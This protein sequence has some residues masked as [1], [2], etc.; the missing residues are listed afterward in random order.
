[1]KPR[2]LHCFSCRICFLFQIMNVNVSVGQSVFR[3]THLVDGALVQAVPHWCCRLYLRSP[4]CRAAGP[5]SAANRQMRLWEVCYHL[6]RVAQMSSCCK[7]CVWYFFSC[8]RSCS[9][10]L[11]NRCIPTATAFGGVC[12]GALTVLA[13]TIIY[14]YLETFEKERAIELGFFGFFFFLNR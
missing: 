4:R 7:R 3:P 5:A 8:A 1:M 12:M 2:H 13:V 6:R 10:L 14:Q 11:L 9:C